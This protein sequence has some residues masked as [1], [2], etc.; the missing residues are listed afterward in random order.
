MS[1]LFIQPVGP[2]DDVEE[3]RNFS[4]EELNFCMLRTKDSEEMDSSDTASSTEHTEKV[5]GPVYKEM[6]GVEVLWLPLQGKLQDAFHRLL[7][8]CKGPSFSAP[9]EGRLSYNRPY[10]RTGEHSYIFSWCMC[11]DP[12]THC[13]EDRCGNTHVEGYSN[14]LCYVSDVEEVQIFFTEQRRARFQSQFLPEP[15]LSEVQEKYWRRPSGKI[16]QVNGKFVMQ[17]DAASG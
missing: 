14:G 8:L 10:S 1:N 11:E 7:L 16:S 4:A 2:S 12:Q 17:R 15:K 9:A 3:R 13:K 6:N 5:A